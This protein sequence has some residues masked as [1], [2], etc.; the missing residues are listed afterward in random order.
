MALL[1]CSLNFFNFLSADILAQTIP[2]QH[3]MHTNAPPPAIIP[4]NVDESPPFADSTFSP[5]MGPRME[6]PVVPVVTILVELATVGLGGM[7]KVDVS[8]VGIVASVYVM[9][10][11]I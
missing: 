10:T 5:A 4:I 6:V 2:A 11:G 3:A 7:V 1:F 8:I 9:G